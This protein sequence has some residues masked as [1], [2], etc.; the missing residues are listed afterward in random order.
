MSEPKSI[1]AVFEKLPIEKV[2]LNVQVSEGGFVTSQDNNFTCSDNC[3]LDLPKG[4]SITLTSTSNDDYTF[5]GWTG[6]C[7]GTT[8]C[9]LL[10]NASKSI[11]SVF[12]KLPIEK[13]T[14]NVQV[15]DGGSVTSQDNNF[16]CSGNCSLNLPKGE[17][18]TLTPAPSA[19]YSLKGWSGACT[20]N[21][22]C[23]VIMSEN[24]IVAALFEVSTP[25]S[26]ANTL[27]ITEPHGIDHINYPIQIGRPFIQG[28]ITHFPEVI[29]SG[30]VVPTQ[31]D[32]K[33]RHTDGSVK[34]A[35]ISFILP[36]LTANSS[37]TFTFQNKT[38]N[39]NIPLTK[40]EMLSY[41]DFDAQMNFSLPDKE[42]VSAKEIITNDHFSYWLQG[43]IATSV[44]LSDHSEVRKY[45]VGSDEHK[46]IRP[47]F[48]ITFWPTIN[49]YSVRFIAEATNTEALQDQ[50]YDLELSIKTD[51]NV[52]YQK[53][54]VPHQNRSR[55]T[56]KFWSGDALK[57]LSINHNISYL[58]QTKAL[59]NFDT[60]RM[61]NEESISEYW[62]TWL[63]K[64]KDI[65]QKGLWQSRMAT[66]GGRPDIGLYPTWTVKWLFTGD[67]RHQEIALQ[68]SSL[69]ASWPIHIREGD[70]DRKFDFAGTVE[71]IGRVLSMA[72][73][74]RPTHWTS[75]PDW[76]EIDTNDK[77]TFVGENGV[78]EWRPDTAHH[79]D[80]AS[81]QYLLTGDYFYLEEMIFSA[82]FVSGDNN[83][84]G[85]NS[86]LGR[87]PTG[88]EGAL[89]SGEV[90][91]Q[92]WALRTRVHTQS[93][94]PDNFPEKAYFHH[95]NNNA[96]SMFEGL[97]KLELTNQD[98][99]E[100]Y[101]FVKENVIP[102]E[103]KNTHTPSTI[104]L[105]DEGV[106]A[107]SYVNPQN[108]DTRK[109]NRA[110]AP[111]M[112][113]FV[114]IALGRAKELGYNTDTLL[115][116]SGKLLLEPFK[117]EDLPHSMMCVLA[118]PSLDNNNAWFTTWND[119]YDQF[120]PEYIEK[121]TS[122]VTSN[123]DAEHG[124]PSIAMAA[125][126]YLNGYSNHPE[127]W[128]F[129]EEK[130]IV[131]DIFNNNPKWALLPRQN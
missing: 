79:P 109:I 85:F 65:Y 93:I 88:S 19:G 31:A 92:A 96:I 43:P 120:T 35:I 71:G 48:H 72:P 106:D 21:S 81:P 46:S 123:R 45:D 55:W 30:V 77:I 86:T 99:Q 115:A 82:A 68:Q 15:S 8:S 9:E 61:P 54:D 56:K 7:A 32:I 76:H 125:A 101:D 2:T 127:L 10:M 97:F 80:I 69:A 50:L 39:N 108:M 12:E 29:H 122:F 1:K 112:Q 83:A 84:K 16:T 102:Q 62:S 57:T 51:D 75:R 74:A 11:Q 90:R 131:K 129:I 5:A 20:G 23:Q 27:V 91:G 40:A 18:I 28:E 38:T 111:W 130:I 3:S 4:E 87:G 104:G 124:Y 128:R 33:Q 78:T 119:I 114:I 66:A 98:N 105:W 89:Y 42:S 73:N 60:S 110:M 70:N 53:K 17:S 107:A 121:T 63:T 25:P 47:I 22:L 118:M 44:I 100:L 6:D 117:N 41:D 26:T 58:I 113:N 64:D 14:L 126:S 94:I 95:I 59:P 103:F 36:S 52:I 34:H 116:F 49:K 37:Q 13:V 67:W 24:L